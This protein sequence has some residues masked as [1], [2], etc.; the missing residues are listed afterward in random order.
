VS[1]VWINT[2]SEAT[3]SEQ[4]SPPVGVILLVRRHFPAKA[5]HLSLRGMRRKLV[6]LKRHILG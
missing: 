6:K 3:T 4:N 1:E 5:F 2:F